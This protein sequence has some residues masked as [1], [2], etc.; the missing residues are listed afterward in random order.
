VE[1]QNERKEKMKADKTV[2]VNKKRRGADDDTAKSKRNK[3]K[4]KSSRSS[5]KSRGSS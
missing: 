4:I 5:P 3:L 2:K 1:P